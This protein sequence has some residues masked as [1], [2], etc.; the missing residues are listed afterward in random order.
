LAGD[1][2]HVSGAAAR[3]LRAL[4]QTADG[5]GPST[6]L[7]LRL[8]RVLD[9]G[10]RGDLAAMA[11]IARG[12]RVHRPPRRPFGAKA[13]P[14]PGTDPLGGG[15][16]IRTLDTVSRIHAFQACAFSRSATPPAPA[17]CRIRAH[18]SQGG[19]ADNSR[20][21]R[22]GRKSPIFGGS[23][24][25]PGPN[26]PSAAGTRS[27]QMSMALREPREQPA[28]A[29]RYR[30]SPGLAVEIDSWCPCASGL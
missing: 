8:S 21:P 14:L 22:G 30:R 13:R 26:R 2:H 24:T 6:G 28:L 27:Q 4:P 19:E 1:K 15:R 16:G 9:R 7:G 18:Y 12:P 5:L 10:H 3:R 25:I 17:G 29:S 11:W 20:S 23:A